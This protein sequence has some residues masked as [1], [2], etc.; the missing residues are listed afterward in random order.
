M[1]P[2]TMRNRF[3]WAATAA[4]LLVVAVIFLLRPSSGA[5]RQDLA[6][7]AR[8]S[9]GS[10]P[11]A[12]T[13]LAQNPP[14]AGAVA[15]FS[16]TGTP[17]MAA[18]SAPSPEPPTSEM[19]PQ[20]EWAQRIPEAA[21]Y[22]KDLPDFH[23]AALVDFAGEFP[24]T[25]PTE[26]YDF[27]EALLKKRE[28]FPDSLDDRSA[29]DFHEWVSR[30]EAM[31]AAMVCAR[32]EFVQLAH[33]GITPTGRGFA[34]LGFDGPAPLYQFTQN[35]AAAVS[36]GANL[37]RM[38][39][40]FD[41]SLPAP[42]DG[43]DLYVNV[44]DHG[45]IYDENPEFQLPMG[46]GTRVVF[47]EINDAGNREHMTHCAGTVGAWGYT[48]NLMGMAPRVWI[49]SHIQQSIGDIT[50]H[51]MR[52]PGQKHT[53]TNPRTGE[54]EMK[55]V[56]GTTS[57]GWDYTG[58]YDSQAAAFDSTLRD[59]PYYLHFYAAAN[60][61]NAYNTLSAGHAMAKN[62]VT[63][64]SASDTLRNASG[65]YTGGGNVSY[66]SSRGPTLD[67]RIKP[68]LTGNGEDLTSPA[69]ATGNLSMSGTSMATPNA[70]GSATLLIDYITRKLP[71]HFFRSSTIKALLAN[72]ATD[73][74]NPGPDYQYGWGIINVKA[75]A[76]VVKRYAENP[77][78]RVLIEDRLSTGQTWTGNYS[79]D[80]SGA[81]RVTIAWIDPAGISQSTNGTTDR[82][83]R[84]INDLN[85]RLVGPNGSVHQ[86]FV[87]PFTTGNATLAAYDPALYGAPAVTGNNFTDNVE[88]IVLAAPSTGNYTL[89]ITHSGSLQNGAP[90]P[91]SVAVS[92][93]S[94]AAPLTPQISSISPTV[95]NGT[96]SFELFVN[97]SGFSLGC[98][99]LLRRAGP[100]HTTEEARGYGVIVVDEQLGARFDTA[101]LRKG[102]WDVVVRSPNGS[103]TILA[104]AFLLPAG[105]L[106]AAVLYRNGFESSEG[107]VLTGDWAV[108]SP[109]QASVG[110]P[111]TAF[112]GQQVLGTYL[113]GNYANSINITAT[114]PPI[115]TRGKSNI[116]LKFRRWLGI[117]LNTTGGF[118]NRHADYARILLSTD[119]TSWSELWANAAAIADRSWIEQTFALPASFNNQ[120]EVFIRFQL[121]SDAKN[122]S[123]GWNLDALEIRADSPMQ[124]PIV[125]SQPP[126][127][128]E[129]GANFFHAIVVSDSDSTGA[130]L[131]FQASGLPAGLSLSN[132]GNSTAALAGTPVVPGEFPASIQVSDGSY[133]TWQNFVIEV[134][135]RR[136]T[137]PAISAIQE[138]SIPANSSIQALGFIIGDAETPPGDLVLTANSSNASVVPNLESALSL[139]GNDADRFISITP[140]ANASGN[141]TITLRVSDG[142]LFTETSFPLSVTETMDSWMAGTPLTGGEEGPNS[143]PD[144]DGIPNLIEFAL[145]GAA[146]EADT[147]ILPVVSSLETGGA[148][149]LQLE[150]VPARTAG[151]RYFIE[152]SSNLA[153]WSDVLEIT[154]QLS[155]GEPY[156]FADPE[157]V[158]SARFLRLRV[159]K[160]P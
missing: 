28:T 89:Q 155:P 11:I 16:G 27:Q 21:L 121:E 132:L 128:A 84:L 104:N 140:A 129:V 34:L 22:A 88:Q 116:T 74:G 87:M 160:D 156:L 55:S 17:N 8:P 19:I 66:F 103:E 33:T 80:G 73:R 78:T 37:V 141:T 62:V 38:A 9:P 123:F 51:G 91:F 61:G 44:N 3:L 142:L 76:D 108:G 102:L 143:D 151:L 18:G 120:S 39:A 85:V 71:G 97:G 113:T 149:R 119:C 14:A 13:S 4:A 45:T 67:G 43:T 36:T 131:S 70:S 52:W 133:T 139:G 125:V 117:A 10:R 49:R 127:S 101:T 72:T 92:G 148:T 138:Q 81:V 1:S 114:L 50:L 57:L 110:G 95:G 12:G 122:V 56:I 94:G 115:N 5:D 64:G 15:S 150:F 75:A 147:G 96:N 30:M 23:K 60:Q 77:S 144:G 130:E 154:P 42:A 7:S 32:A 107:L 24:D 136:N 53:T 105:L 82:S 79:Y 93:L 111:G 135:P 31:Q 68:D 2:K 47:K 158:G 112:E 46:G 153:N 59:Y 134:M 137:A 86:P 109:A 35:A 145:G 98:D 25:D 106:P 40:S 29:K 41:P 63:V 65:N 54:I 83:P 146:T 69:T 159:A 6:P 58:A 48:A 20:G 100:D 124:P 118:N 99:V 90:Q 26:F 152:A 126:G 157:P